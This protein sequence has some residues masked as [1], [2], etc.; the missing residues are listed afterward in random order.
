MDQDTEIWSG[1]SRKEVYECLPSGTLSSKL[2]NWEQLKPAILE[3]S[4]DLQALIKKAAA[5]KQQE[6]EERRR[7]QRRTSQSKRRKAVE[8]NAANTHGED[9]SN[10][11]G[12]FR[13]W[14]GEGEYMELPSPAEARAHV[15]RF[16]RA[17]GNEAVKRA[18][19]VVCA[20]E[21]LANEG[22]RS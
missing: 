10:D 15:S 4:G 9:N 5:A 13:I 21:L 16:L 19:C 18:V 22:T 6:R 12:P 3:L 7:Q 17:T 2:R 8:S 14:C 11:D 20:R 1:L